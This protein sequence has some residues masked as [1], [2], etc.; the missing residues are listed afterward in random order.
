MAA[1]RAEFLNGG[2]FAP[3]AE[4]VAR[5]AGVYAPSRG[6]LLEV[7]AGTGYY[8][9]RCLAA[10]EGKL[11]LA[12]DVSK[13]AAPP[14]R[15]LAWALS[16]PTRGTRFRSAQGRSGSRS[17]YCYEERVLTWQMILD[18]T[19]QAALAGTLPSARHHDP[20]ELADRIAMLPAR[21]EV[22]GAVTLH[23]YRKHASLPA[24]MKR[25]A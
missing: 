16:L 17:F 2:H 10:L 19:D 9:S 8:L 20:S 23:V 14:G 5:L 22:W 24:A 11:G 18:R 6:L 4:A 12:V 7:G 15:I 25:G 13:Q 1:A 3:L 21:L